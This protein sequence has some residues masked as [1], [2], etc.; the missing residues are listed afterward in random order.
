M[1]SGSKRVSV[2]NR[3]DTTFTQ[4]S[5]ICD[6]PASGT[7]LA[8]DLTTSSLMSNEVAVARCS[9]RST[10][11]TR[12][13]R[14]SS[15]QDATA[16]STSPVT[17]MPSSCATPSN[18]PSWSGVTVPGAAMKSSS[19]LP[20]PAVRRQLAEMAIHEVREVREVRTANRKRVHRQAVPMLVVRLAWMQ[21]EL[22]ARI[23]AEDHAGVANERVPGAFCCD[24]AIA[25]D[26]QLMVVQIEQIQRHWTPRVERLRSAHL[27]M[28]DQ[29][30]I[31][32]GARIEHQPFLQELQ[33]V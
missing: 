31:D 9:D 19:A 17:A 2:T 1:R 28:P 4:P 11:T 29:P 21:P 23:V 18:R 5:T 6:S 26:T 16:A 20:M 22:A 33:L 27:E 7:S 8:D 25:V 12:C 30:L 32:V 24:R 14:G 15:V 3:L 13:G 10:C